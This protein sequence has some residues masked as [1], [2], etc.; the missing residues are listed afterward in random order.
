ME[1]FAKMINTSISSELAE[2]DI[3]QFTYYKI[4]NYGNYMIGNLDRQSY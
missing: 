2:D 1:N 3:R 4:P